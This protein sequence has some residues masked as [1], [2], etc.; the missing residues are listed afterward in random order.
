M[1]LGIAVEFGER[2]R[3]LVMGQIKSILPTEKQDLVRFHLDA[4]GIIDFDQKTA[5]IDAALYDSRLAKT[6][7]ISG[8]MAM[9]T[10]WGDSPNFALAIGGFHPA[11]NPPPAFPKV[12]RVAINL[13]KG[14]NPRLRCEAYFALT[15]NTIQFGARAELFASGAGFSIQ[16]AIGFDVLIQRSPFHFTADFF[17]QVQL[18]RGNTNLFK[19][20]VEGALSGPR[21]LNVKGK[22]TFEILWWDF[23]V[24]F[25]KTLIEG[26]RPP[27]PE[28]VDVTPLLTAALSET[29]NWKSELPDRQRAMVTLRPQPG[30]S[31]D[32]LLH[33]LGTLTIKQTVVPLNFDISRFG[34]N[35]PAGARRFTITNV[36]FGDDNPTFVPERDFFAPA[37]FIEMSDDQKLSRPSFEKMDAGVKFGSTLFDI[38]DNAEDRLAVNTIEFETWIV[39]RETNEPRPADPVDTAGNKVHYRISE[40]LFRKQARFGAAGSSDLRRSGK[41]RY[42]TVIS[43]YRVEKEGWTIVGAEDLTPQV[44]RGVSYSEAEEALRKVRLADPERASNLKILRGSDL[45]QK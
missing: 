43:K 3:L 22:A 19:V 26:E 15:S 42:R 17:A 14:D 9:R 33:P 44:A 27:L 11:F 36:S 31:T 6:F 13:S 23:S 16:G 18:K 32:V 10:R 29:S 37:Q 45:N 21:P 40:E 38:P 1:S 12:K 5:S 25:D 41:A 2:S 4:V 34:P 8:E 24:R 28:V 7:A 20:R 35:P 30:T 39:D